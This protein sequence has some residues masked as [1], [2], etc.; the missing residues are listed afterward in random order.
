MSKVI[1]P[2][3]EEVNV[4]AKKRFMEAMSMETDDS[5]FSA[6][7]FNIK[8]KQAKLG[9][10]YIRDREIMKRIQQGQAIRII[11][12]ISTDN[13]ERKRYIKASMPNMLPA[14]V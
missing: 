8:L 2:K 11:N 10:E 6:D 3:E 12:F 13:D 14:K 5:Y 7:K 4:I 9:M 1:E